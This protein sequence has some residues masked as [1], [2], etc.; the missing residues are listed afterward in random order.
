MRL[1]IRWYYEDQLI[2]ENENLFQPGLNYGW[3]ASHD[4]YFKEG[5]YKVEVG[6]KMI[7]FEIEDVG[8]DNVARLNL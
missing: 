1:K 5:R 8:G 2:L 6:G 7:E 3:I 4:E